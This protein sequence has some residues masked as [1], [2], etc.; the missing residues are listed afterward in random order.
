MNERDE[1]RIPVLIAEL[2]SILP[3]FVDEESD[4]L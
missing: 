3:P 4:D 2:D 1:L